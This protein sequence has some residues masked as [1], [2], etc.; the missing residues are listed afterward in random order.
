MARIGLVLG[1]GGVVGHAFHAGVLRALEDAT[2]WD[3]ST[4][5]IVV[6]TSAGSVV[7]ALLRADR[8][9]DVVAQGVEGEPPERIPSRAPGR[10]SRLPRMASPGMFVRAAVPTFPPRPV[11]PGALAAAALPVGRVS[12]ELVA[13]GLRP[14]FDGQWPSK[15][16]WICAVRLDTGRRVV[17]GR[18]GSPPDVEVADA[19]A[20]SCAIPSFFAPVSIGAVRYVDGGAHS[21]TNAD[22]L[23]GRDL[24][25]DLVIV[26]SPMSVAGN[27]MRPSFDLPA[28]RISRL[29]LGREVARLQRRG[30]PVLAFQPMAADLAVMGLNAMDPSRRA[31]VTEQARESALRRLE[32]PVTG[33]GQPTQPA[34]ESLRS[35]A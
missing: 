26:S 9:T 33:G 35:M 25:L 3:P 4:A 22:L 29:Y 32:R 11:R 30:I 28:R 18:K 5:E 31:A 14:L 21:P 20:A 16:L 10:G 23:A 1:A 2:G 12:T 19:V 8:D 17:F 27:R 13:A 24:D 15:P 6:G 7:G 34:S